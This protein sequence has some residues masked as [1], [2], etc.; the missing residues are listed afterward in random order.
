[1]SSAALNSTNCSPWSSRESPD[2]G[3]E[4]EER[5]V[6][7]SFGLCLELKDGLDRSY[8]NFYCWFNDC[9]LVREQGLEMD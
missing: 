1:M 7:V 6:A 4:R 5:R 9:V 3:L 2:I 8:I